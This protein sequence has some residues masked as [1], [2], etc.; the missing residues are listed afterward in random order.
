[1]NRALT[2]E[3]AEDVSALKP[4]N[5]LVVDDDVQLQGM[6]ER[7]LTTSGYRVVPAN[8][9]ETALRLYEEHLRRGSSF[10]LVLLDFSLPHMNGCECLTRIWNL[11]SE[12]RVLITTGHCWEEEDKPPQARMAAGVL[13]KPFALKNLLDK[14]QEILPA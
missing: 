3:R 10:D 2:T 1:M 7:V 6:L 4:A 14:V 5:L 13:H 8:D 9:G 11:D 12:A